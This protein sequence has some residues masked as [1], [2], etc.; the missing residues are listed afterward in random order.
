MRRESIAQ[1]LCW[2]TTVI[3]KIDLAGP[4]Q[5]GLAM[6]LNE[7]T[8]YLAVSF[9]AVATGYLAATY[10]LLPVP[11]YPGVGI[12]L[13]GLVFS[14]FF[15]HETKPYAQAEAKMVAPTVGET[16]KAPTFAQIFVLTSWKDKNLFSASQAGM[17]NNL[18]DGLMWGLY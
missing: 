2:S 16:E 5:R 6:G 9:A 10:G 8:G 14:A 17:V 1:G 18:N 12:A 7:F 13:A 3:M 4:K 15:I 11:F